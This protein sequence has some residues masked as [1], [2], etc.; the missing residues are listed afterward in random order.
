MEPRTPG[1]IAQG[2]MRA[3]ESGDRLLEIVS[4]SDRRAYNAHA[5]I[6]EI[7]DQGSFFEV[8]PRFDPLDAAA[9]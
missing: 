4:P 2:A 5:L 8:V 7:V 1:A 3:V 6:E 9:S